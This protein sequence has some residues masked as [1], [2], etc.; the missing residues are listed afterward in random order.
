MTMFNFL[1][2]IGG[3]KGNSAIRVSSATIDKIILVSFELVLLLWILN[4]TGS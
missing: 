1:D 2:F 4:Y 3:T